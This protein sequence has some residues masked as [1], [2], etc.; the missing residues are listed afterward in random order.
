MPL[1]FSTIIE[2]HL[3]TRTAASLFDVGHMGQATVTGMRARETLERLV[4]TDLGALPQGRM[5]YSVL[6]N[7]KGGIVDDLIIL[8]INEAEFFIVVNAARKADDFELIGSHLLPQV[9]LKIHRD[10]TLLAFQGPK[11]A[12]CLERLTTLLPP[13]FLTG[14]KTEDDLIIMRSGYTGEDGF[15]ISLPIPQAVDFATDLAKM[16]EVKWCGL[17]ARDT[18]RLEAG[19]CL[20][21]QDLDEKTSP[22]EA[23]LSFTISRSRRENKDFPGHERLLKELQQGP[24]RVRVGLIPE[25]KII[26][27]T[28]VEIYEQAGKRCIGKVT[29]GGYSPT[30][31]GPIAMGYI[32]NNFTEVGDVLL[33]IRDRMEPATLCPLPFVPPNTLRAPTRAKK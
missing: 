10:R 12:A 3:H 18:L 31:E 33:K 8:K 13:A 4:P 24:S 17:G 15:E 20:Y 23:G 27:R 28:G 1:Q 19:L 30:R 9:G 2:E 22:V 14:L 6:L 32:D 21:G 7:K 25:G 11:A 16:P 26:A 5:A 29:S